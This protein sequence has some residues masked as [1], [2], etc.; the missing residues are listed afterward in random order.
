MSRIDVG[1][2]PGRCAPAPGSLPVAAA[3]D[4]LRAFANHGLIPQA[5]DADVVAVLPAPVATLLAWELAPLNAPLG[6]GPRRCSG[7]WRRRG[8]SSAECGNA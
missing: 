5:I 2:L 8:S 4:D 3:V 7:S 1:L 6:R